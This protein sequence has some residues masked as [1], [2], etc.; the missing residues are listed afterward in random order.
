[1]YI[2]PIRYSGPPAESRS[3][4]ENAIYARLTELG[5]PFDRVDH[6]H[7]DTMEDCLAI[8]RVLGGKICKN[9]FLCNRQG[10]QFY[11]LMMIPVSVLL[12]LFSL[13]SRDIAN[14][15]KH[16]NLVSAFFFFIISFLRFRR[17]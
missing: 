8:E 6:D 5:I 10:T 4:P 2:D 13:F 1:M 16:G 15:L 17:G 11:L 14:L 9:L 7:A 3:E 12:I